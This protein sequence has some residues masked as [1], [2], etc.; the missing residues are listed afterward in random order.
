MPHFA[1]RTPRYTPAK[2]SE[3]AAE[4]VPEVLLIREAWDNPPL[5]FDETLFMA[6]DTVYGATYIPDDQP[7]DT[8]PA[9]G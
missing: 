9:K 1:L 2:R 5:R 6:G 7:E 8:K 3:F 4:N